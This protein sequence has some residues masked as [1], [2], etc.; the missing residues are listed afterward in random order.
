[1]LESNRTSVI[2]L[3]L[4]SIRHVELEIYFLLL[5]NLLAKS[6]SLFLSVDKSI[7]SGINSIA[8]TIAPSVYLAN[9]Q[10]TKSEL[11]L[12]AL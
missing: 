7:N 2:I 8:G 12:T 1:M 6:T 4:Y 11:F 9:P 3:F 10:N 5:K